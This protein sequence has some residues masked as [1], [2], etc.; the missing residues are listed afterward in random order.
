[1][2][3]QGGEYIFRFSHFLI[4][5]GVLFAN[6]FRRVVET[7]SLCAKQEIAPGLNRNIHWNDAMHVA[8]GKSHC[9]FELA[10]SMSSRLSV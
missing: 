4:Y 2:L 8:T 9:T 10:V 5:R 3:I 7:L 1:M 6:P